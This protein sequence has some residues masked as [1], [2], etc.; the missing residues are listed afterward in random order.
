MHAINIGRV[1]TRKNGRLHLALNGLAHCGAGT[2]RILGP[3]REITAKML[4]IVCRRCWRRLKELVSEAIHE[5]MRRRDRIRLAI[6]NAVADAMRSPAEIANERRMLTDIAAG[7][8]ANSLGVKPTSL[9]EM[10][11]AHLAAL[12]RDR[13]EFAVRRGQLELCEVTS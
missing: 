13:E 9:A 7:L 12:Q 6:L 5:V 11:S 2:G 8:K 1:S 10:R 4:A 3:A